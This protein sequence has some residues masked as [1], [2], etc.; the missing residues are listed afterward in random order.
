MP[1]VGAKLNKYCLAGSAKRFLSEHCFKQG[2][3]SVDEC[4]CCGILYRGRNPRQWSA[5]L[6]FM[7]SCYAVMLEDCID[8]WPEPTTPQ[9]WDPLTVPFCTIEQGTGY[10]LAQLGNDVNFLTLQIE[11]EVDSW[12]GVPGVCFRYHPSSFRTTYL[13]QQHR[14]CQASCVYP[15][16]TYPSSYRS[17]IPRSPPRIVVRC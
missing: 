12:E 17:L 13:S 10:H 9:G 16:L 3:L 5:G 14:R 11:V 4:F 6:Y 15:R 8:S 1:N 2:P 7:L